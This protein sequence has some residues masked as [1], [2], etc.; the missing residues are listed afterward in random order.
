M[1]RRPPRSTRSDTPFPYTT[2]CRSFAHVP[3][4]AAA[5]RQAE[6]VGEI[7]GRIAEYGKGRRIDIGLGKGGQSRESVEDAHVE[8]SVGARVEI[9]EAEQALQP[10]AFVE[11]LEFLADLFVEIKAGDVDIDR[12]QRV[13]V[14][15]GRRTVLAPGADRAERDR[16]AKQIGR[17]HV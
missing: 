3:G 15:R 1:F 17:A 7:E 16:I 11:K 6:P 10:V 2:L 8:Q 9:I 14:D 4:V 12:G 13:E 5:D